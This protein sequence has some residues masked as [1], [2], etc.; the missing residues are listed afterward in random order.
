MFRWHWRW[1]SFPFEKSSFAWP[2]VIQLA[3]DIWLGEFNRF[4]WIEIE[5]LKRR[6][7]HT[8]SVSLECSR[9]WVMGC[10]I[11]IQIYEWA[12]AS[13]WAVYDLCMSHTTHLTVFIIRT[14]NGASPIQSIVFIL[15]TCDEFDVINSQNS[16]LSF[17]LMIMELCTFQDEIENERLRRRRVW[18]ASND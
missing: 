8:Q 9:V 18:L 15:R 11:C 17:R 12:L 5:L 1:H 6:L 3:S 14:L 2:K 13:K 16:L 7:K 4:E 10:L